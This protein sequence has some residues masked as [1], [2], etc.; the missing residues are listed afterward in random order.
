MISSL[1]TAGDKFLGVKMIP[2]GLHFLY[3]SPVSKEGQVAPRTGTE[4]T[5]HTCTVTV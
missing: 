3:Y 5:V 4:D 2:P 1:L